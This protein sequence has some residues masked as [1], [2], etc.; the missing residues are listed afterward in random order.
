M[1]NSCSTYVTYNIVEVWKKQRFESREP[2]KVADVGKG[3]KVVGVVMPHRGAQPGSEP[4][5]LSAGTAQGASMDPTLAGSGS[6]EKHPL[7]TPTKAGGEFPEAGS[8]SAE[9]RARGSVKPKGAAKA[10]GKAAKE[11]PA[12]KKIERAL[13]DYTSSCMKAERVLTTINGPTSNAA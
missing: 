12:R 8:G 11:V 1:C 3:G 5:A 13:V 6:A 2:I 10:K 4:L 7:K 9:K